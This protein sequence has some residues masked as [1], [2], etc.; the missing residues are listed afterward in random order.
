MVDVDINVA[1]G[2]DSFENHVTALK[3]EGLRPQLKQCHQLF[4]TTKSH[5][6]IW[7]KKSYLLYNPPVQFEIVMI[8][9]F[10]PG[11]MGEGLKRVYE[12]KREK[13]NIQVYSLAVEMTPS[14]KRGPVG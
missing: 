13:K 2:E 6:F 10:T 1:Y 8:Y 4:V 12:R 14:V 11:N 9:L 3:S 5:N 7:N